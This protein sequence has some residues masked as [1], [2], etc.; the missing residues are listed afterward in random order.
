MAYREPVVVTHP[1]RPPMVLLP[2][3][4]YDDLIAAMAGL[5]NLIEQRRQAVEPLPPL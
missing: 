5:N 2:A 1:H 3:E 4:R